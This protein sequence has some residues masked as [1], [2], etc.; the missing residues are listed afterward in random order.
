M[1][2]IGQNYHTKP[3]KYGNKGKIKT[4]FFTHVILTNVMNGN[5]YL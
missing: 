3:I 5:Y 1:N 2:K 4:I